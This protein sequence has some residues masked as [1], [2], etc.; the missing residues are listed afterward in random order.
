M[1]KYNLKG[2]EEKLELCYFRVTDLW[3]RLCE[4]HTTLLDQTCE[5]YSCLLGNDLEKLEEKIKVKQQTITRITGLENIREDVIKELNIYL[6]ENKMGSVFS[7]SDL[8][9]L[10]NKFELINNQKH[11]FRFNALLIDIITKIQTQN[12]NNQLFIN[13]SLLNLKS[14]REDALGQKSYSTYNSNGNSK[15]HS[16]EL[17]R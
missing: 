3:R 6:T 2:Y 9:E 11:L 7:I 17:G 13:R 8:I 4:E 5:E 10:M 12:K 1:E 15:T 14:I 16:L